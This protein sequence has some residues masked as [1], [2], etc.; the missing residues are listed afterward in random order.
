MLE[1]LA[2]MSCVACSPETPPLSDEE[3]EDLLDQLRDWEVVEVEGAPRLRRSFEFD[4]FTTALW[5]ADEVG[6][7]AQGQGHYPELSTMAGETTVQWW[8]P[9]IRGLHRNDFVMAAK[10][11]RIFWSV[12]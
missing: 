11:D 5:F 8:T 1:T 9:A 12:G 7:E 3:R 2:D 4:D 6:A 10:T